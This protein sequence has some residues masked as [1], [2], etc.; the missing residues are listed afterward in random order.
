MGLEHPITGLSVDAGR[1]SLLP[2][3]YADVRGLLVTSSHSE[4]PPLGDYEH[5]V[6][7]CGG[8]GVTPMHSILSE[9]ALRLNDR[10]IAAAKSCGKIQTVRLVWVARSEALFQLPDFKHTLQELWAAGDGYDVGGG[11]IDDDGGF[12]FDAKLFCTAKGGRSMFGTGGSVTFGGQ[13][14]PQPPQQQPPQPHGGGAS[15][16]GEFEFAVR[17][18]RPVLPEVLPKDRNGGRTVVIACGPAPLVAAASAFAL[19]R[20]CTFHHEVFNW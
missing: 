10:S 7:V 4:G 6:L 2:S 5:L 15:N 13:P 9:L 1:G 14:Q 17:Y 3:R 8:I 20:G 16:A 12:T 11:G 19:D 18:G